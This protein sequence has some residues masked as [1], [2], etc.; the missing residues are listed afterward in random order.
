MSTQDF[1]ERANQVHGNKYDYSK[2]EYTTSSSHV[3]IICHKK[4]QIR[5][6]AW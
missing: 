4:R 3:C 2:V 5:A 1:I 6:R